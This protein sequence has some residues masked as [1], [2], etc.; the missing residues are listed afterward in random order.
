MYVSALD[1]SRHAVRVRVLTFGWLAS[2]E[3]S[4]CTLLAVDGAERAV[5]DV[6]ITA[7]REEGEVVDS[8]VQPSG[9]ESC[10]RRCHPPRCR[11]K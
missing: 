1:V 5:N 4:V 2:V 9:T 8:P 10:S 6:D 7:C 11:H 3:G